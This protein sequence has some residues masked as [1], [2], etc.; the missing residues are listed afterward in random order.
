[1]VICLSQAPHHHLGDGNESLCKEA[2]NMTNW[3]KE[4]HLSSTKSCTG[5]SREAL[6]STSHSVSTSNTP[7]RT[8]IPGT[9]QIDE[10]LMCTSSKGHD[11]DGRQPEYY[12]SFCL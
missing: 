8:H 3:Q 1:M 10:P 12:K 6:Y 5:G 7:T 2:F 9:R 11:D 4:E